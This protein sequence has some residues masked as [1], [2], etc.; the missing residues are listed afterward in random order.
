VSASSACGAASASTSS[1]PA[2]RAGLAT[3]PQEQQ[4]HVVGAVRAG[5]E[6][7][8]AADDPVRHR[9]QVALDRR[10]LQGQRQAL[11]VEELVAVLRFGDAVAEHRE[12]LAVPDHDLPFGPREARHHPHR[13]ARRPERAQRAVLHQVRLGV[14]GVHVAEHAARGIQPAHEQR[15]EAARIAAPEHA[16]VQPLDECERPGARVVEHARRG[17]GPRHEQRGAHPLARDVAHEQGDGPVLAN[18]HVV[19]IPADLVAGLDAC[20]AEPARQRG[21]LGEQALLDARRRGQLLR[22]PLA[23]LLGFVEPHVRELHRRHV[24]EQRQQLELA[25]PVV[26]QRVRAVGIEDA[27]HLLVVEQRHG[28]C[29]VDRVRDDAVLREEA[30]IVRRIAGDHRRVLGQHALQ[31]GLRQRQRIVGAAAAVTRRDLA[32]L[33]GPAGGPAGGARA[34]AEQDHEPARGHR[35]LDQA[36]DRLAGLVERARHDEQLAGLGEHVQHAPGVGRGAGGLLQDVAHLELERRAHV[37]GRGEARGVVAQALGDR[38][39]HVAHLDAV[40]GSDRQ[41]GDGVAPVHARA[42]AAPEV[43]DRPAFAGERQLGVLL[44]H[45]AVQDLDG[46]AGGTPKAHGRALEQPLAVLAVERGGET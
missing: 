10:L 12:R 9:R 17:Q 18:V 41:R 27:E 5:G 26:D 25:L 42:V 34:V 21:R 35:R 14:A 33:G 20:V 44:G 32:Q 45:G 30:R 39:Q 19:E 15:Q 22:E 38:E 1:A 40:A 36:E 11:E 46:V 29:G 43:A 23:H 6:G 7:V 4:R 28:H 8:D 16:R 31:D 3:A 13:D 37:F 2:S 24:A